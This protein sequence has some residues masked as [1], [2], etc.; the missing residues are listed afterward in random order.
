M[1]SRQS[2][3]RL[4]ICAVSLTA[5][6]GVLACSVSAQSRPRPNDHSA[7]TPEST[8]HPHEIRADNPSTPER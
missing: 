6:T 1:L 2:K 3:K 4:I 5:I 8:G 7:G